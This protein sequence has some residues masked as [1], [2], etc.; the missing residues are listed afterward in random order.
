[1]PSVDGEDPKPL[2]VA[3]V[4][5]SFNPPRRRW[6]AR[7]RADLRGLH[8]GSEVSTHLAVGGRRGRASTSPRPATS[9]R[10]NPPRRRWTARTR[11]PFAR[12]TPCCVSTH[13]AVGGRRGLD[14]DDPIV[15]VTKFQPTSP[16]V[17][18]EDSI[19][20]EMDPETYRFQP[21]SPSVDG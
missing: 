2:P 12:T 8:A 13:L 19:G 20:A 16:S 4:V 6:T 14:A 1:S 3:R 10:Y 18:G 7:T 5:S 17:D 11:R 21:T 9:L 15:Q